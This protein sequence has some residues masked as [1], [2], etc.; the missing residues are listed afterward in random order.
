MEVLVV[1]LIAAGIG[2]ALFSAWRNSRRDGGYFSSSAAPPVND[3]TEGFSYE[4]NERKAQ[5][6]QHLDARLGAQRSS[7][8]LNAELLKAQAETPVLRRLIQ[9]ELRNTIKHCVSVHW[10]AATA[11]R[12]EFIYEI[13]PE[14]EC[15]ALRERVIYIAEEAVE[16]LQRYP[17]LIDQPVLMKNLIVIR[18][19][20]LPTC[21]DCPYLQYETCYAPR[22]CPSAEFALITPEETADTK[23]IGGN[24]DQR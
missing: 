1:L 5:F 3:R 19:M 4:A 14:P 21:R 22:N 9:E 15:F 24:N 8:A 16:R 7:S 12:T 13:A 17:L 23:R 20:I 2:Y 6:R 11:A 18:S 10:L